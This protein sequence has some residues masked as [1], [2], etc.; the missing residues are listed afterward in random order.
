MTMPNNS[1][2]DVPDKGDTL[3]PQNDDNVSHG[4]T[5]HRKARVPGTGADLLKDVDIDDLF[6]E[7]M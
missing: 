4:T 1:P 3:R 6:A 5:P 7:Y 2:S